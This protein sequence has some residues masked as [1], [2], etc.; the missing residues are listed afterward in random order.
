MGKKISEVINPSQ[1][2]AKEKNNEEKKETKIVQN[3]KSKESKSLV[4]RLQF[5]KDIVQFLRG[6]ADNQ[7]CEF[8]NLWYNT[9]NQQLK[10]DGECDI[11]FNF[12]YSSNFNKLFWNSAGP[13]YLMIQQLVD[14]FLYCRCS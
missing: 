13:Q 2:S 5:S 12:A 8:W 9:V 7:M 3:P 10:E 14:F 4:E 11:Q 1:E 6:G